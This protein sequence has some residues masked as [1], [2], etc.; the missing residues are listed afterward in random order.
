M[1]SHK[2]LASPCGIVELEGLE[3]LAELGEGGGV[4]RGVKG[5]HGDLVHPN[6]IGMAISPRLI[7]VGEDHL[8]ARPTDD[9]DETADRLVRH[10]ASLGADAPATERLLNGLS[11]RRLVMRLDEQYLALGHAG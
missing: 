2:G 11:E 9:G 4:T 5:C 10:A 7:T 3:S 1:A 8:R 6:M